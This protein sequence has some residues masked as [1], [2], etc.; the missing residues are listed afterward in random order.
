M[1]KKQFK[2]ESK[3]L[4]ELMIHSIYTNKEIFLREIISNA[5]DAIDKLCYI[6]LTD[7]SVGLAREDFCI[8]L[9]VDKDAR[10]ITVS[11]NG[12]G[13]TKEEL[14][15]NLGVIA[16]SGSLG[17]KQELAAQED[18]ADVDVDVIGQFGV[19]FYSAFMV[20]ERVSVLT[21]AHGSD[22]AWLWESGGADGYS[23]RTAEKERVGTDIVM[24][25]KADTEDEQYSAYLDTARLQELIKKYSDYIRW[26]IRMEVE[27]Y[28]MEETGEMD[29]NGAPKIEYRPCVEER[30]INSMVPIWQ[31]GRS[32][33]SDED[34]AAFYMERFRD[35]EAPL[36]VIRVS[37]EGLVSFKALLFIPAHAP[38][39]YYSRD[40]E[41]GLALYSSGVMI[42]DKCAD[43]LPECF[44]FVR[45]VVDSPDLSLNISRELLQHD[46]QLKVIAGSIEKKIKSEL[47]KLMEDTEKYKQFW[48]S[49]GRQLKYGVV[50]DFGAKKELLRE[51]LLFHSSGAGEL[52]D[53]QSY[54]ER[55]PA[56]QEKVYYAAAETVAKAEKLPQAEPVRE[57]GW[58]LLYLCEEVD[59]FVLQML[60]DAQGK[61]FCNVST[62]DLGLRSDAEKAETKEKE[63]KLRPALECIKE[64]LGDAV[65]EVRLSDKLRTMPVCLSTDGEVTLE[66]ERYFARYPE[67]A[68]APLK[69]RR[70]L[71]LNAEHPAVQSLFAKTAAEPEKAREMAQLLLAQAQ[72]LAG[73]PLDDPQAHTRL[74]CALMQ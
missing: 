4:L 68:A 52:T 72:L 13:M 11:D 58:E 60:G 65:Y 14:E 7:E 25:L 71:E 51:L 49:F 29:E 70:V 62:E 34:C 3:K 15:E 6:A 26:P 59:E 28:R 30:T 38:F 42:M 36:R 22:T 46:R 35:Y 32:E 27:D 57:R 37:A 45:G 73:L 23:I 64:A 54:V 17:F 55:M 12:V 24:Q 18:A 21:R 43:L 61:P 53:L 48:Q 19:G 2:A 50:A 47:K 44:A 41:A 63:E 56:A 8:R 74:V 5:S 10:T 31:R 16:H 66:M 1:A 33:V 69:A 40:W 9:T 39:N 20:A 67:S